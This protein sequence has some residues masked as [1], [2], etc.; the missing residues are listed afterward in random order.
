[1]V[2]AISQ[3]PSL[4]HVL[5]HLERLP[6]RLDELYRETFAR[7]ATKGDENAL[8][9]R[10]ALTWVAFAEAPLSMED[11]RYA[12]AH[13]P[14]MD[15][16]SPGNLTPASTLLSLC[17]GLLVVENSVGEGLYSWTGWTSCPDQ[18]EFLDVVGPRVRLVR[19]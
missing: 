4:G 19:E 12:V 9:A 3:S 14:H 5:K 7:I 11:L 13:E 6:S 17:A 18:I 1:M 15:S 10:R 16:V 8:I 2:E